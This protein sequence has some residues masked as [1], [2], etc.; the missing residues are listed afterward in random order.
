MYIDTWSCVVD[1]EAAPVY[2]VPVQIFCLSL[3]LVYDSNLPN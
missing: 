2:F 1:M 3:I